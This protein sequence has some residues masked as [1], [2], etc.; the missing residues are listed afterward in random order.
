MSTIP[1]ESTNPATSQDE[2]DY[3]VRALSH[4]MGANFMVLEHS[5]A[6]LKGAIQQVAGPDLDQ[7]V[8]HV[9]ACLRE[10]R[11]FLGD[12]VDLARTGT[13]DMQPSQVELGD[14]VDEVLFEQREL[15]A[16]RGILVDV[17]RPLAAVW[18]NPR[19]LKQVVTNLVR[20]AVKHG[21][22]PTRPQ[23]TIWST[24]GG[25]AAADRAKL[26]LVALRVHDNGPGIE[27]EFQQE[28]FRPGRRLTRA[29]AEGS[30][31]GLAIV[32]KIAEYYGGSVSV[33]AETEAGTTMVVWLPCSSEGTKAVRPWPELPADSDTQK[34][35]PDADGPHDDHRP[36]PHRPFSH[37]LGPHSL[38]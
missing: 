19:R 38:R 11:R 18:C 6:R 24:L 10:S 32:K 17:R 9:E 1:A 37:Q 16:E 26:G 29:S 7:A 31:I 34:Q 36:H 21:C 22:D 15:L 13:V 28:I 30:G 2:L 27:P 25:T 3:L 35:R 14:V 5:F 4:D 12:L 23:M 8:A 20:N 33:D